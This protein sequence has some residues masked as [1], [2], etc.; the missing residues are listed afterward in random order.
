[1]TIRSAD[2]FDPRV[3]PAGRIADCLNVYER[4]RGTDELGA[5]LARGLELA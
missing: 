5:A 4:Q 2:L 1:V 3:D